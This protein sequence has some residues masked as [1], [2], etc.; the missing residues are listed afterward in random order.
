MC[1]SIFESCRGSLVVKVT[2]SW[3]ACHEFEPITTAD[4]P[5]RG[6]MHI[7]SVESSHVLPLLWYL[8]EGVSAQVSASSL[9]HDSKLPG[10]SSKTLE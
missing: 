2:D 8:G 4:P 7:K 5:C 3:P 10:P 6:A 9:D 1:L